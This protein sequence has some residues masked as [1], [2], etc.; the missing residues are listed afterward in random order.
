MARCF[1][2]AVIQQIL[3]GV[4]QSRIMPGINALCADRRATGLKEYHDGYDLV[5]S[6]FDRAVSNAGDQ[7]AEC[8]QSCCLSLVGRER[9]K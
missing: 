7:A 3:M 4:N 1:S 9:V 5:L 8:S 6:D 2:L